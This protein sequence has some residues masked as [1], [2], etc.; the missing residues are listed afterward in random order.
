MTRLR[1]LSIAGS[2]SGGG[3]GI[4]AD[5]KTMLALGAH[6]MSAVTAITAQ[7]SR[8]VHGIWPIPVE[9]VRAQ[10]RAVLDDMGADAVK[11]GMLGSA[12]V[13][14]AVAEEISGLGVPIVVDPVCASKHGDALLAPDALD[15]LRRTVLPLATVVTPNLA[16]VALLTGVEV[17]GESD[18]ADA[19]RAVRE[20]GSQWALVKGGHLAGDAVDLL[21]DGVTATPYAV[22]RLDNRHTHG[23]GCTLSSAMAVFLA[24]GA[25]MPDAVGQAKDYVTQ[26]IAAGFEMGSGVGPVDHAWAWR[27]AGG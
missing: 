14:E 22:A 11:V 23:T 4:Q 12:D 17:L 3:A 8:G 16:E 21:W 18:L 6:G 20:L 19:A 25:S 24:R 7:N 27:R 26:A 2:D 10:I 9:A 5:L 13:A 15:V 1:V